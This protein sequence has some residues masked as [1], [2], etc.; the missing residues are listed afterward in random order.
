MGK[1]DWKKKGTSSKKKKAPTKNII[2]FNAVII[3]KL[4]GSIRFGK[5]KNQ[6]DLIDTA[7]SMYAQYKK[8]IKM[9]AL[10][11]LKY[12]IVSHEDLR[13][14]ELSFRKHFGYLQKSIDEERHRQVELAR[15]NNNFPDLDHILKPTSK[16][17][18][19]FIDD[20][21]KALGINDDHHSYHGANFST[22]QSLRKILKNI[23]ENV[24]K[25]HMP[26]AKM[27]VYAEKMEKI[28][29]FNPMD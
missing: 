5:L 15:N 21:C 28:Y 24:K 10:E 18:D 20:A 16:K 2:N 29:D 17:Y 7:D 14:V 6:F 12:E 23:W 1:D 22:P 4:I 13:K 9:A 3:D 19:D 26:E 27:R 8:I 11:E 25:A